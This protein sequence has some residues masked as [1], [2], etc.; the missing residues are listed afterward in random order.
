VAD[1]IT[2]T[3]QLHSVGGVRD[4]LRGLTLRGRAFV[5]A[6]ATA[7]LCAILLGQS[8]LTRVGVLV[9]VL[10]I[11]AAIVIG[12]G[13]TEITVSRSVAPR[14]VTA[15][16]PARV[17]LT[18]VNDGR[19]ATG[20]L[21]AEDLVPYALG[22]RSRFVLRGLSRHWERK[23]GY[24]VRSDVR[25]AFEI[26]PL[27]LRV[28]DPFGLVE[29]RR[30]FPGTSSLIVTPRTVSLPRI[31]LGGGWS[32]TGEHRPQAFAAGS[33]ED[34]S[35]REYRRGDELRRVHW[36]SSAKVGEL[37]VRRE[38]QP[39]EAR[40]TV[41]LDDRLR[42]HRG[43]GLASS[44]EAAV[45]VA[46]SILVHLEQAGYSVRLVTS[47]G[48]PPDDTDNAIAELER[49]ALI[50]PN[51]RAL[52]DVGWCGEQARGGLVVAVLGGTEPTDVPALRRIRHDASS[53]MAIVLDV[54][55]WAARN[56]AAMADLPAP[57][58]TVSGLG[59]RAV[60]VGPRDRL[61]RAWQDLGRAAE[62]T[63]SRKAAAR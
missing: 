5:A 25:G 14:L 24:Q 51:Q 53:A 17:D 36:R 22:T 47:A 57:A 50:T 42:A 26:G 30:T 35:V 63:A 20:A 6:G 2:T 39:W 12:R 49:L 41:L 48:A 10:P 60:P 11:V 46:A 33:A 52:L 27:A 3:S 55:Q 40:A 32:G 19:R 59:W 31:P 23:V 34:V 16:Q 9:L 29:L 28:A 7:I 58:A 8:A 45:S 56:T 37:M 54:D 4:A 15:G 21:L 62:R 13:R 18:I 1:P 38:E 44:F 61:D 43:Q